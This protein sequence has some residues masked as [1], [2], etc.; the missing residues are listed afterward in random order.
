VN[1]GEDWSGYEAR[2]GAET[3]TGTSAPD[4]RSRPQTGHMTAPTALATTLGLAA[5]CW[6]VAVRRMT[7]M[8]MGVASELGS[9]GFFVALWVAMMAAMMLPGTAPAVLRRAR[10]SG[11]SITVPLFLASYLAIWTLA[12]V[13]VFA[14]YRPHGTLAAG[15]VTIGAGLYELTPPKRH[16]RRCCRESDGPG[17]EYGLYC[18]GS[19]VGPMLM[20][21]AL[22]VMSIAWMSV[23]AVLVLFQ[24]LV[25]P[26][27]VIDVPVGLAIVGLGFL[28]VLAPS[29]VPGL[30][31]PM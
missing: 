15:A 5:A 19:S 14:L 11:R 21:V 7:P 28:I 1:T 3:T 29:S 9:F 18:V 31:P 8:D 27:A 10:T 13:A 25:R 6:I 12:G 30:M 4:P 16:L 20:F 23:I 17:F 22:G 2:Q 26:R 24:K